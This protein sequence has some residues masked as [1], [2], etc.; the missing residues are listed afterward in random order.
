MDIKDKL[1]KYI[2]DDTMSS[3]DI[4]NAL[5]DYI[6]I[7]GPELRKIIADLDKT[8]AEIEKKKNVSANI[9]MDFKKLQKRMKKVLN[10]PIP[11]TENTINEKLYGFGNN[12]TI[13]VYGTDV[14][15]TIGGKSVTMTKKELVV[16]L[17]KLGIVKQKTK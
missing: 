1:S 4:I 9:L 13:E 15:F 3:N 16:L 17:I 11:V 12:G 5:D 14:I 2:T 10:K 7:E 8:M 6:M